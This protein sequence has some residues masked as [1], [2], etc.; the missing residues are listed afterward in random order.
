MCEYLL[1]TYMSLFCVCVWYSYRVPDL[2]TSLPVR[3]HRAA[4]AAGGGGGGAATATGQHQGSKLGKPPTV[5]S[6]GS[7]NTR[8]S[9]PP[10]DDDQLQFRPR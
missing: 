3:H 7:A 5:E 9:L 1:Y 6:A 4:T 8:L 10:I 2:T